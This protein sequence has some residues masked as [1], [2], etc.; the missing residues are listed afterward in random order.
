V[1]TGNFSGMDSNGGNVQGR[2]WWCPLLEDLS[3]FA[4]L[5]DLEQER[6]VYVGS[7]AEPVTGWQV[8]TWERMRLTDLYDLIL[9]GDGR[10][11][12]QLVRGVLDD[13]DGKEA[14]G[15]FRVKGP[16]GGSREVVL[17]VRLLEILDS[18]PH[19]G[20]LLLQL[21]PREKRPDGTIVQGAEEVERLL[22]HAP[23]LLW[24][25][26]GEG[27][28]TLFR[29]RPASDKGMEPGQVLGRTV[30]EVYADEPDICECARRVLDGETFSRRIERHG[31][32]YETHFIPVTDAAGRLL[33]AVG[34]ASDSTE[35]LRGE[36]LQE[37]SRKLE[38]IGQLTGGLAH[39]FN[40]LLTAILGNV[41]LSQMSSELPEPVREMLNDASEAC[42]RARDLI[43]DLVTFSRGGEPACRVQPLG[44]I[45]EEVRQFCVDASEIR[46][47]TDL[48]DDLW[49]VN[50][51]DSQI[52]QLLSNLLN[53]AVEAI[54]PGGEVRISAVNHEGSAGPLSG[55]VGPLVLLSVS[56]NGE[57]ID[58]DD[59]ERIFEPY[60]TTRRG[61][62]GL[63]LTTC[64]LIAQ[65]HGGTIWCESGQEG[66]TTFHVALPALP[67][68]ETASAPS[69]EQRGVRDLAGRRVLVM[70]DEPAVRQL[71][72]RML[73][74][75]GVEVD[76]AEQ[77]GQAVELY[78]Q[79]LQAGR[80]Y[81]AVVLDLLVSGGEGGESALQRMREMDPRVRAIVSSASLGEPA[82]T[83]PRAC[84]FRAAIA[85]PYRSE[86]LMEV[87]RRVVPGTV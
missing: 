14:R 59:L 78:R 20:M 42:L 76:L 38:S 73:L 53:N 43:Q 79:A 1:N 19:E 52:A 11:F 66:G 80:P 22:R 54:S 64:F 61:A 35:L 23:V 4:C 15:H 3:G 47:E 71:L 55:D 51:D 18:C 86:E 69:S 84:G 34:V 50:V 36:R 75:E 68:S 45:I 72:R 56:D 85:K 27:R 60:Y 49:P 57:G 6:V 31:R 29:G 77:G 5:Y 21:H 48:P 87:L 39:D 46:V 25:L 58:D 74:A 82:M 70:D 67:Q 81:D 33:A 37:Q 62:A 63:G 44:P 30:F 32:I 26:D 10:S 8:Q 41:N 40:N 13:R 83:D 16:D 65:R 24:A 17:R 2:S 12:S 28:F 9:P 7:S